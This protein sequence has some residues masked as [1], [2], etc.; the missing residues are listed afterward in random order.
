M[1]HGKRRGAKQAGLQVEVGEVEV[2]AGRRLGL[3]G[4]VG[5][6]RLVVEVGVAVVD[7]RDVLERRA[8]FVVSRQVDRVAL[9]AG[10][11]L[12]SVVVVP[13][14]AAVAAHVLRPR[15]HEDVSAGPELRLR[16]D[17]RDAVDL[18][19]VGHL[20]AEIERGRRF[21]DERRSELKRAPRV[22]DERHAAAALADNAVAA[23]DDR[24][25]VLV[26][27]GSEGM[28]A[29]DG[30]VHALGAARPLVRRRQPVDPV[31]AAEVGRRRVVAV[32]VV[33]AEA[34]VVVEL[35]PARVEPA[36]LRVVA[37]GLAKRLAAHEPGL[38]R[39]RDRRPA[40]ARALSAR[41]RILGLVLLLRHAVH[42]ERRAAAAR[43]VPALAGTVAVDAHNRRQRGRVRRRDQTRVL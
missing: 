18:A 12:G 27:V 43:L 2:G 22:V 16:L 4:D 19:L 36:V 15:E 25:F 42:R 32:P 10:A 39:S 37:V 1:G 40:D 26:S 6:G 28:G 30:E 20:E 5:P 23:V 11:I 3:E 9:R 35:A 14:E 8:D 29:R 7:E 38:V 21:D 24:A 33:H 31:A 13:T 41:A 34:E 17:G